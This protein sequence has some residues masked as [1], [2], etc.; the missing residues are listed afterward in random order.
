MIHIAN[1]MSRRPERPWALAA[2][3]PVVALIAG[4]ACGPDQ[5]EIDRLSESV[6]RL[7]QEQEAMTDRIAELEE[8]HRLMAAEHDHAMASPHGEIWW[9]F[10]GGKAAL[11]REGGRKREI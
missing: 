2:L 6:T 4:S 7:E 3:L 9:D 5:G 8:Q 11:P 1:T 10:R